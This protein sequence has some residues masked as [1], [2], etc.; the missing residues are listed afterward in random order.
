MEI[1]QY[2]FMQK[3]FIVEILISIIIPMVG[4]IIVL[5]RLSMILGDA[6]SHSSLAG[7][8]GGL[9]AGI[10]P[11]VGAIIASVIGALSIE[12][13]RKKIPRYSEVAIAIVMSTGIGLCRYLV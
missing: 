10:N 11:I 2:E 1:F 4:T 8:A 12:Y 6:L 7:I 9:V 13:I 5:K 3:A